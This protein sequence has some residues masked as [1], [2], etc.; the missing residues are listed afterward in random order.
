MVRVLPIPPFID[1]WVCRTVVDSSWFQSIYTQLI[2]E[3]PL[4]WFVISLLVWVLTL[5][6]TNQVYKNRHYAKLGITTVSCKINRK[7]FLGKLQSYLQTK[8]HSFEDRSY[9]DNNDIVRVSYTEGKTR[10]SADTKHKLTGVALWGGSNPTIVLEYDERNR[11]LLTATVHYN[12]RLAKRTL[13]LN[14]DEIRE[15]LM[16]EFN[17]M[18][19]WDIDG[20]DTSHEDLAIDRRAALQRL[21]DEELQDKSD[22]AGKSSVLTR[23]SGSFRS[24]R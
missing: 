16:N 18:D 22:M 23:H 24:S 12:R 7:I 9:A 2:Q 3:A 6:I 10:K 4:L 14:A 20:E 17:A 21:F 1:Q 8:L 13:V 5:V 11:Y 15:R 19:I